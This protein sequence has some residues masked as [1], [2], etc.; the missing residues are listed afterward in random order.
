M[1]KLITLA[2]NIDNFLNFKRAL[3]YPYQRG[4]ATLKSFLH[5]AQQHG[6]KAKTKDCTIIIF[7][8]TLDKWL[9]RIE[10]RKPVTLA[11]DLGVIRQLCL[12]C[13][14]YDPKMFVPKIALAPQTESVYTPYIFSHKEIMLLLQAAIQHTGKN[15]WAVMLYTLLLVLYCTGLRFGEAIRLHLSEVDLEQQVFL[16][17]A[18]KGRTRWVPFGKDLAQKLKTYLDRR[19][20]ILTTKNLNYEY[21]LFIGLNGKPLTMYAASNA[22]RK[23][24]RKQGLKPEKGR[25]G[26][27][28]FDFRHTFAVHR[29]TEWYHQNIDIHAQLPWLSAYM[30]HVNLLGTEAYL[31]ATPELLQFASNRFEHRFKNTEEIS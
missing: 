31:R 19:S 22:V 5:F 16:I 25:L 18:S 13:R 29:L 11:N 17:R 14:R 10:G 8:V 9:Y 15:I 7:E 20:E 3:G 1:I 12:Y 24:L 2:S 30:G 6:T 21:I 27:R 28:P 26:P 23:L 4:E